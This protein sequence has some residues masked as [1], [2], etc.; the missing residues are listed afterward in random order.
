M[1][2]RE[3]LKTEPQT[4]HFSALAIRIED[5]MPLLSYFLYKP[6]G[7]QKSYVLFGS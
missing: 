5:E 1:P 4:W 6:I 3:K 7:V 2:L